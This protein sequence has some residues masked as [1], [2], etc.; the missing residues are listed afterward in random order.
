MRIVYV[1]IKGIS[2]V[3]EKTSIINIRRC[4]SCISLRHKSEGNVSSQRRCYFLNHGNQITI[5][6]CR[7]YFFL[8]QISETN[9]PA[10]LI[11]SPPC[12]FSPNQ[13][14]TPH[15]ENALVS[16]FIPT[17]RVIR[18]QLKVFQAFQDDQDEEVLLE[19]TLQA[20]RYVRGSLLAGVQFKLC[21]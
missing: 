12:L 15:A 8:F 4:F 20:S 1:N 18:P 5:T 14:S 19:P 9:A 6:V 2:S 10:L 7:S 3:C 16:L 13:L 17:L 21:W 11:E